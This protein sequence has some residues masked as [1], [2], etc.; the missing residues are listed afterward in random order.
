MSMP[1][2]ENVAQNAQRI[3]AREQDKKQL[4]L[5]KGKNIMCIDAPKTKETNK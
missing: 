2:N 3:E 5:E 1:S 4:R